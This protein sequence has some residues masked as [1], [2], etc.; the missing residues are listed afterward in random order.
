MAQ[1]PSTSRL[2]IALIILLG[3]GAGYIYFSQFNVGSAVTASPFEGKRDDLAEF[4]TFKLNTTVLDNAAYQALQ[5]FGE[6]PVSVGT[7]GKQDP[8]MP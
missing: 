4:K 1:K 5:V 6:L 3:F 7:P 8:F 2:V